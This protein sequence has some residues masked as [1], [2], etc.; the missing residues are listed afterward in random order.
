MSKVARFVHT[1]FCDDIRHEQGNKVSL[2]GIYQGSI[3]VPNGN[4]AILP[5]LHAL[6]E[7]QTP[8]DRPFEK[9]SVELQLNGKTIEEMV[10]PKTLLANPH[11]AHPDGVE[12][13]MYLWATL[14]VVK[15]LKI[16]NRSVLS[17][18]AKTESEEYLSNLIHIDFAL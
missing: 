13:I 1:T 5:R 8:I 12:P 15:D 4:P 9:L 7:A 18:I 11:Q 17:V 14:F 16:E 6:V 3:I 10:F 2:M